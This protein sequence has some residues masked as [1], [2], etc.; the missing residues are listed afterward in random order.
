MFQI[1]KQFKVEMAHRL[2]SAYSSC[3]TDQIHGH[4]YIIEVF[5]KASELNE[6]G[7]VIDFG[8]LKK[9]IG[10]YI[11]SWDHAL[12][13]PASLAQ[14]HEK[15]NLIVMEENPTAEVMAYK[16]FVHMK[17]SLEEAKCRAADD[18]RISKV[19]VHETAT[20]WAEY[21]EG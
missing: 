15:K 5:L 9:L 16:M 3:C 6:D 13:M 1:R 11:D 21:E 20:G 14:G 2:A 8:E 17:N 19:R 4:S 18:V 10:D 7:M 12:V